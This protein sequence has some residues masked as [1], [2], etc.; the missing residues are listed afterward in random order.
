MWGPSL[1]PE[2]NGGLG[3]SPF[4]WARKVLLSGLG[5]EGGTCASGEQR[6]RL[7]GEGCS[8]PRHSHARP[9]FQGENTPQLLTYRAGGD[10][11]S[12]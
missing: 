4:L 1:T 2:S 3:L 11:S 10:K 12:Y 9:G 7:G 8:Q 5:S 6:R